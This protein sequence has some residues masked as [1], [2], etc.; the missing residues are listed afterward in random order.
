MNII[1][2]EHTHICYH[3]TRKYECLSTDNAKM[4]TRML[5]GTEAIGD[6]HKRNEL[7]KKGEWY[8]WLIFDHILSYISA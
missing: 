6:M 4:Y 3:I 7:M 1:S 2:N 5:R 8:A